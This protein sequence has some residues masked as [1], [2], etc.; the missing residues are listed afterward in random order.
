MSEARADDGPV[1]GS[2]RKLRSDLRLSVALFV[3]GVVIV[4]AYVVLQFTILPP[5]WTTAT[6]FGIGVGGAGLVLAWVGGLFAAL[7][8]SRLRQR[9]SGSG[10][11]TNRA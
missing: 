3:V 8:W 10:P 1:A 9:P 4:G 2:V 5:T 7:T 11:R 6:V